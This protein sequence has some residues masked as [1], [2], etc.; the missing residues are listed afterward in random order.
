MR[1]LVSTIGVREKHNFDTIKICWETATLLP[2]APHSNGVAGI[3]DVRCIYSVDMILRKSKGSNIKDSIRISP[4][5]IFR[6][7]LLVLSVPEN[8][9]KIF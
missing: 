3:H 4:K 1:D 2:R 7:T 8:S 6:K 9:T 5:D